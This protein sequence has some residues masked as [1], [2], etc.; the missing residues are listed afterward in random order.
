MASIGGWVF[1]IAGKQPPHH[2][3]NQDNRD[4]H[5]HQRV[6]A[7]QQ[8]R[9]VYGDDDSPNN[10][11]DAVNQQRRKNG[12]EQADGHNHGALG[13]IVRGSPRNEGDHSLKSKCG[14]Q[15]SDRCV[16]TFP[17]RTVGHDVA[18]YRG[19]AEC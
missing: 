3:G 14:V 17:S 15:A 13:N 12:H 6:H 10:D 19:G 18:Q 7:V 11:P 8:Q 5:Q 4:D 2:T 9:Q 1:L 16:N